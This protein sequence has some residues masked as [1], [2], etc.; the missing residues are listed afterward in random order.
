MLSPSKTPAPASSGAGLPPPFQNGSPSCP[1]PSFRRPEPL[2]F[3]TPAS[4]LHGFLGSLWLVSGSPRTVFEGKVVSLVPSPLGS[5]SY[6]V[7]DLLT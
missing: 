6:S 7:L 3:W 4:P 5:N 2:E 1:R